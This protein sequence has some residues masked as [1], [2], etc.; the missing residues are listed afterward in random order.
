M[1]LDHTSLHVPQDKFQ[2]CLRLYL[3]A[4]SPLGYEVRRQMGETVV[5]LGS[6][7]DTGNVPPA[8][9]W[10]IG[11]NDSNPRTAHLAF[12][13]P[14]KFDLITFGSNGFC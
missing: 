1:G 11:T 4:L 9:F 2:E 12:R 7:L 6:T 8:D 14:G 10:V 3:A 5:A 13:A